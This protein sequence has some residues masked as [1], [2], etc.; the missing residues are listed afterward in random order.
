[1]VDSFE[2]DSNKKYH[3]SE[4]GVVFDADVKSIGKIDI[5]EKY[6][7]RRYIKD[8][9]MEETMNKIYKVKEELARRNLKV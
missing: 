2:R 1:M 9:L 4:A 3:I 8:E 5:E 6:A 7:K